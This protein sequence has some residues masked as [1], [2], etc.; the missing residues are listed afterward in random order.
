MDFN[1][2][3]IFTGLTGGLHGCPPKACSM[4]CLREAGPLRP[5]NRGVFSIKGAPK[6]D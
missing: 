1:E 4:L 3:F 2:L 6:R 5:L